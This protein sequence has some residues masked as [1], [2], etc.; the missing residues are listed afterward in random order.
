MSALLRC[1]CGAAAA[2][3][4]LA[5]ALAAH[6][7]EA[8]S[9]SEPKLSRVVTPADG[10]ADFPING[11]MR[12]FLTA[13]PRQ[14]REGIGRDYR[15][16]DDQGALVKLNQTTTQ[17]MAEL[18]PVKPLKPGTR[19]TLEQA[20]DF[21][22]S[23]TRLT[24]TERWMAAQG[25]EAPG[26][27][28][29]GLRRAFFGVSSFTTATSP[30][31]AAG[32]TVA[33][34]KGEVR[35]LE[36][37]GDC[38]PATTLEL[39]VALPQPVD[40]S[41]HLEVEVEGQGVVRT[42][43]LEAT[44][45]SPLQVWVSDMLCVFDPVHL[46]RKERFPTRVHLVDAAGSRRASTA[47]FQPT[48]PQRLSPYPDA[49]P[50][51]LDEPL[52]RERVASPKQLAAWFGVSEVPARAAFGEGAAFC[53]N[54]LEVARARTYRPPSP[55]HT[56]MRLPFSVDSQ[57][58]PWVL[59]TT[60]ESA[61]RLEVEGTTLGLS[62]GILEPWF[63]HLPDGFLVA[64]TDWLNQE[65]LQKNFRPG[66]PMQIEVVVERL[67]PD[68]T[69]RWRTTLAPKDSAWS[70]RAAVDGQLALVAW[71]NTQI[72]SHHPR[73][74]LVSLKDGKVIG[75]LGE[76]AEGADEEVNEDERA[77][78]AA[79]DDGFFALWPPVKRA[80]TG[81]FVH[82]GRDGTVKRLPF[83]LG[84]TSEAAMVKLG[85]QLIIAFADARGQ[86][87]TAG[88]DPE[89]SQLSHDGLVSLGLSSGNRKPHLLP[90][91]GGAILQW[92]NFDEHAGYVAAV[93][94]EGRHS[95]PTRFT[96]DQGAAWGGLQLHGTT[97]VA[98]ASVVEGER[99]EFAYLK[100][101]A[102][103]L[104]EHPIALPPLSAPKQ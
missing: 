13:F 93:D 48:V 51:G 53:P 56:Q 23:G 14:L 67:G 6:P 76:G 55:W 49:R 58:N 8:C 31:K 88:L 94:A 73:L 18:A 79:D 27:K 57:G 69:P 33:I 41:E 74:A 29:A 95:L 26:L 28:G 84:V 98:A 35:Y 45:A 11:H 62:A 1:L 30:A 99:V 100:C 52:P 61:Y 4:T 103:R 65:E 24:D 71:V 47:W 37:G 70:V 40:R 42:L 5:L 19:Y 102:D 15:L 39:Q 32:A 83:P 36:G 90:A 86:L 75:H 60:G 22:P 77:A 12:V 78:I 43:P 97:P 16:R 34:A 72:R 9:C 80:K 87:H 59:T 21:D 92:M 25:V 81:L 17:T 7:A 2:V 91:M 54:G 20:F 3:V 10:S 50:R 82:V 68:G 89:S 64:G 96:Q 63:T 46:G 38:G 85:K 44:S 104:D 101:R 66:V